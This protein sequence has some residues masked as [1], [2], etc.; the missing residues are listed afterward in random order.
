MEKALPLQPGT[1]G[2]AEVEYRHPH[3]VFGRSPDIGGGTGKGQPPEQ[4]AVDL[5]SPC[6]LRR[7]PVRHVHHAHSVLQQHNRGS[8]FQGQ[9]C[10]RYFVGKAAHRLDRVILA[11]GLCRIHREHDGRRPG[12]AWSYPTGIACWPAL[13]TPGQ[14]TEGRPLLSGRQPQALAN[15]SDGS[16]ARR[17]I[18]PVRSMTR[19]RVMKY[20]TAGDSWEPVPRKNKATHPNIRATAIAFRGR[21]VNEEER[22]TRVCRITQGNNQSSRMRAIPTSCRISCNPEFRRNFRDEPW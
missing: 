9:I 22:N 2:P 17:R 1:F 14:T 15:R 16:R 7:L 3:A 19:I 8:V 6:L 18:W 10:N 13:S 11:V 12:R 20:E 4:P 5:R 21:P